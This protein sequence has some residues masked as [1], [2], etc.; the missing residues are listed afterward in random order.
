MRISVFK[1][2]PNWIS[3]FRAFIEGRRAPKH[4]ENIAQLLQESGCATL[5]GYLDIT[6]ALSLIDT[7][8]VKPIGSLLKWKDVS[9]Y[10]HELK[11]LSPRQRLRVVCMGEI[12]QQHRRNMGRMV[13]SQNAGSEKMG[14]YEC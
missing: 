2:L 8:W 14:R 12:C 10:T 11:E 6:H 1:E 5:Q 7:Y 4:R 9:L 13:P 3:N